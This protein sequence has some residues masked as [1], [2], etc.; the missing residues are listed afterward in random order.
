VPRQVSELESEEATDVAFVD[1]EAMRETVR[2][3]RARRKART[4]HR[5]RGRR[6]AI[7]FWVVLLALVVGILALSLT[8]WH[9]IQRL[10]GL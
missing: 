6:A 1:H 7:R 5:R 2:F 4:E 3:H 10:F 9:E 8:V